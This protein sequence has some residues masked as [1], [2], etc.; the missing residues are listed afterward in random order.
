MNWEAIYKSNL[1]RLGYPE[2][3]KN[4]KLSLR[5]ANKNYVFFISAFTFGQPVLL[6]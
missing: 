6:L 1:L 3:M 2:W 4:R 5:Q